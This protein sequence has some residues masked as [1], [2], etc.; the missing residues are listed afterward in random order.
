MQHNG[1]E[2][3]TRSERGCDGD[4]GGTCKECRARLAAASS[5]SVSTRPPWRGWSQKNWG[6]DS[7]VSRKRVPKA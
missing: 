7:G 2:I 6:H 1:I 5:S 3:L 4:C